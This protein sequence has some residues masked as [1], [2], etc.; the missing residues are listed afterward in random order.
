VAAAILDFV[1]E[2]RVGVL[3]IGRPSRKGLKGRLAPGI[4][5]RVLENADGIDVLV[6][7]ID[8]KGLG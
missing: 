2:E 7:D 4:V 1:H 5:Q 3:V 8:S 6:A